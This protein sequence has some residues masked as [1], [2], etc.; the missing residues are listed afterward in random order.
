M[1]IK[2]F[3]LTNGEEVICEVVEWDNEETRDIV[4]RKA[5][6]IEPKQKAEQD[7]I[8]YKYYTFHPWMAMQ[9][10]IDELQT[11]NSDHVISVAAPSSVAME[12]FGSVVEEVSALS[13]GPEIYDISE[14]IYFDSASADEIQLH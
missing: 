9:N 14:E 1:E 4:I 12:Y 2:H 8:S 5:L 10:S 11:L 13:E 7:D 6:R 3:K